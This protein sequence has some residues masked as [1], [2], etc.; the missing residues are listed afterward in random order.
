MQARMRLH[1]RAGMKFVCKV[2]TQSNGGPPKPPKKTA[3]ALSDGAP[4][5]PGYLIK[6]AALGILAASQRD[7]ATDLVVSPGAEGGTSI[8]YRIHSTW[9]NWSPCGLPWQLMA[10]EFGGLAGIRE[11]PYPKQGIIYMAYS[12]V[13]L[14]WHIE[15]VNDNECNLHD[16]GK[17]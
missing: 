5:G 4:F 14:R 11:A 3:R 1:R 13:R 15:M 9:H 8:R 12:G 17:P 7:G 16:L 10:A 6:R 2:Q